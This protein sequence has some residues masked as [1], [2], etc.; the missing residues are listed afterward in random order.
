MLKQKMVFQS[1]DE[2][3]ATACKQIN[4]DIMPYY[5]ITAS[6]QIAENIDILKGKEN[7]DTKLVLADGEHSAFGMC[8]GASI[9]GGRVLTATSGNGLLYALEQM[10]VQSGT[11]FPMVLNVACTSVSAPMSIKCEHSDI[12]YALNTGFII[13]FAKDNQEV[14]DFNIMGLKL[15]EK[16]NLPV[17]IAFDGFFVSHQKKNVHI[18]EDDKNILDFIGEKNPLYNV[19]DTKNPISIGSYMTELDMINNKYQIHQ[20]MEEA[21]EYIPILFKEYCEISGRNYTP[22]ESYMAKDAEVIIFALGSTY[23]AIKD[24]VEMLRKDGKKVGVFTTKVLRPSML[25]IENI[26]KEAKIIICL[27]RQD[28]YG[29]NGGNMSL[30]LK[31]SLQEKDLDAKVITRIYGL[32]GKNFYKEDAINLFNEALNCLEG[33]EIKRFDYYG[34]YEG[35]ENFIPTT[36]FE[37]ISSDKLDIDFGKD[38]IDINKLTSM[39]RRIVGGHGACAGCGIFPN[40]NMLLKAIKTP[41][42]LLFQTG[43]GSIV[44]S[45]YPKTSFRTSYVHNLLQNGAPTLEG[46]VYMYLKDAKEDITFVMVTGDGGLDIGLGSC[47][48]SGIRKAKFII[49]EYDNCG[50]MTTGNQNSYSSFLGAKTGTSS[51]FGSPFIPRD[52]PMLF[53]AINI[54][55]IATVCESYPE[56]FIKKSDKAFKYSKEGLVF[57]KCLS[58]C[59]L[60]WNINPE[61][62]IKLLENSVKSCYFPLYEIE[63]G[64]TKITY[65]PE[66]KNEKIDIEDFILN[67][68]S[69]KHLKDEK[70]IL[71]KI[72]QETNRKWERLKEKDKS[73]YL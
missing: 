73:K 30:E 1:G 15:A 13:L 12:M 25:D 19:L 2:L 28:S 54:P 7:F 34:K 10:P 4:Y 31:A 41:V 45:A 65:N 24:G 16:V 58:A 62:E 17:I 46:I 44:S 69:M 49:F 66:D 57:I 37:P 20:A 71:D 63:N 38:N 48:S 61:D 55:Y 50:Y 51:S 18:F 53:D 5:P 3:V 39:P 21:K 64:K 29:A 6:T 43:C 56:D 33:Q 36:Y 23:E 27:D 32:S 67:I 35:D 9:S 68:G 47:L 40:L 52:T 72:R 60:N 26:C 42:V 11:R 8:Y 14:Y 22:I 59:P 70:A